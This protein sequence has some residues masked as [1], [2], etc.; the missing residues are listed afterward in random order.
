MTF[1]AKDPPNWKA[2]LSARGKQWA[3]KAN[4]VNEYPA[5]SYIEIIQ[6]GKEVNLI[7]PCCGGH[8]YERTRVR[9]NKLK[10]TYPGAIV[11]VVSPNT[12]T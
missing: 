2:P 9:M 1:K 4:K 11:R 3:V 12:Q 7:M 5:G 6:D 8:S 10:Q